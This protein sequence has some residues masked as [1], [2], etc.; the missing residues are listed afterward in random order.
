MY[1][2]MISQ[3]RDQIRAAHGFVMHAGHEIAGGWRVMEVWESEADHQAWFEGTVKPNL[4]GGMTPSITI[5]AL[6]NVVTP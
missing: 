2:G 6:A 1:S 4:P 3:L 5:S